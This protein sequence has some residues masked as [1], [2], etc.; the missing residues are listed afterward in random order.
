MRLTAD[1]IRFLEKRARF[2]QAWPMVGW[3]LL[4]LIIGLGGFL[5]VF[6]PR[7]ANPFLVLSELEGH[8][9]PE[10]SLSLMAALLPI[11]VLMCLGLA[12]I[13]ILFAFVAFRNEKQHIKVIQR[14]TCYTGNDPMHGNK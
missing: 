11:S 10:S 2:V 12:V 4:C 7:L 14:F 1:E 8:S 5:F 13:I 3:I 6:S 9:I